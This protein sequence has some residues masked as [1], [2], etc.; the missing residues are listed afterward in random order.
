MC[1]R[2]ALSVVL[3]R[4]AEIAGLGRG[5]RLSE[6]SQETASSPR[7][8]IAPTQLAPVIERRGGLFELSQLPWGVRAG[9]PPRL[10]INARSESASRRPLFRRA[11]AERRCLVPTDGFY[12]WEAR[13]DGKQPY[14]V[15]R[16]DRSLFMMAGLIVDSGEDGPRF[17]VLTRQAPSWLAWLHERMPAVIAPR[18]RRAWLDSASSAI[19]VDEALTREI[20]PMDAVPVSRR[21]N[22]ADAEGPSCLAE[23][24]LQ[25]GFL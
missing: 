3:A 17:V 1:G 9:R 4:G 18:D 14:H 11:F 5:L 15:R 12:E 22:R 2:Y 8:N 13:A 6:R 19:L 21:V 7:Y 16:P 23:T 10:V 20:E 24:T 25:Q